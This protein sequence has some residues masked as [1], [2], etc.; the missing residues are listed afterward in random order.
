[1]SLQ[2]FG[3]GLYHTAFSTAIRTSGQIPVIQSLHIVALA[4]LV[5]SALMLD[6]RLAGVF[7]RDVSAGDVV[8]RYL[9][10]LGFAMA[11][12]VASGSLLVIAEPNRV[13][14]NPLFWPKMGL[15]L[16]AIVLTLV[17]R[18]PFLRRDFDLDASGL[19]KLSAWLSLAIWVA[20]ITCG[21]WIAYVITT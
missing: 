19:I 20:T 18:L 11:G 1:M 17:A 2:T 21:R 7:A 14:T 6:L 12:M 5:G 15:L 3:D 10:W 4:L 9:P 8:R 16:A 13:L